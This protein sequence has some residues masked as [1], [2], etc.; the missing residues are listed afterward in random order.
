MPNLF[1]RA[2]VF[3]D[4]HYGLKSNSD[5][6]NQDCDNFIHWMVD[7]ARQRQ[8]E[9]CLFL[10]DFF[11]TRNNINVKTL[12]HAYDGLKLLGESFEKTFLIPGNH[13]CYLR[14]SRSYTSVNWSR[15][16]PGIEIINQIETR[17][18]CVFVPWLV[19]DEHQQLK[20]LQGQYMFAHLELPNFLMNAM[21]QMPDLG[22]VSLQDLSGI[23]SVFSGHFHHRQHRGNV[24]YM[25]NAFPHNFAD[26]GDDARGCMILDWGCEP[27]FLAW[28]GAPKYRV[29]NL[30]DVIASPETKLLPNSYVRIN[31]DVDLSY[32][33]AS[34]I[35]ETFASTYQLR[36][37]SLMPNKQEAHAENLAP[38]EV[39]FE[40]VDQIVSDQITA[41]QSETYDPGLLMNIYQNL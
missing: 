1:R 21:V 12:H 2:M 10:G 37:I 26:A 23:N 27:E 39:K 14:D 5:H 36:E 7:Q 34:C 41:I 40:S 32:E 22:E 35:K 4:L 11:H 29:L 38:G 33:E 16:I 31:L 25:G 24:C 28:P 20:Q 8:C 18:N 19:G 30:S 6:H 3:T 15:N 13:D 17:D 9:T